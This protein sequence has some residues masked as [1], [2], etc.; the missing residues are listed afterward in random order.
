L[1]F[2]QD[3]NVY[4]STQGF[5]SPKLISVYNSK[6]EKIQQ[7]GELEGD[8]IKGYN[9]LLIKKQIKQKKIPE[10][11]KNDLLLIVHKNNVLWAVHRSID[12]FKKF[13]LKDELISEYQI[14]AKEYQSI[15][16][17]FLEKNK[18]EKRQSAY[19]PL[20]YV[21][22]LALDERG[23]LYILLNEPSIMTI[24]VYDR[25]GRFIQ[26]LIG[27]K[28]NIYRIA[29]SEK[30][31]LYALSRETQYIYKFQLDL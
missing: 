13:S 1:A 28:D 5:R 25:K 10:Y 22:D 6:G 17:A 9:F 16:Q 11:F 21:N 31:Y 2:D 4:L 7:I 15:Y 23:N 26:K 30:G 20:Y 29:L 27:V 12:K 14:K 24:Y 19:W 18:S 3:G 8:A